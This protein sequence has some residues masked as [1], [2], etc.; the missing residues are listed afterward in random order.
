MAPYL[1]DDDESDEPIDED[2][3]FA[4]LRTAAHI[5]G[6]IVANHTDFELADNFFMRR[7]SSYTLGEGE[8]ENFV[9]RFQALLASSI[10]GGTRHAGRS[11]S[12]SLDM[13]LTLGLTATVLPFCSTMLPALRAVARNAYDHADELGLLE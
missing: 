10:E 3:Y 2:P 5:S 9:S 8:G 6:G 13:A 4:T 11:N 12:L 7:V 1:T